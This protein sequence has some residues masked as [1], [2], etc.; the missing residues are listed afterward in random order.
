MKSVFPPRPQKPWFRISRGAE[1]LEGRR[2]SNKSLE[3]SLR[4][5]GEEI[6]TKV[7][8]ENVEELIKWLVRAY[9]VTVKDVGNVVQ[10]ARVLPVPIPPDDPGPGSDY[11]GG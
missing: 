4:F 7:S 1:V 2:L 10:L 8:P 6:L 11:F 3:I 9:P 5:Q